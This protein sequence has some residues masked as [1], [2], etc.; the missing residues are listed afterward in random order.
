MA[1]FSLVLCYFDFNE[2]NIMKYHFVA[3]FKTEIKEIF[4]LESTG[5]DLSIKELDDFLVNLYIRMKEKYNEEITHI[6]C[7]DGANNE[8]ISHSFITSELEQ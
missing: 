3:T 1:S 4:C 8:I 5:F 6:I 7:T 2:E